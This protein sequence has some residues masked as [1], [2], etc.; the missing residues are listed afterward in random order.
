MSSRKGRKERKSKQ[1]NMAVARRAARLRNGGNCRPLP[2]GPPRLC[3]P[4]R[5]CAGD[6]AV[7]G[8]T[9]HACAAKV[10]RF[11]P[12]AF[13]A[14][15]KGFQAREARQAEEPRT[16]EEKRSDLCRATPPARAGHSGTVSLPAVA[17]RPDAGRDGSSNNPD[18]LSVFRFFLASLARLAA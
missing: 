13:F 14:A 4:P 9:R 1:G 15:N 7:I 5:P 8:R 12:F 17:F 3:A 16:P 18:A 6:G 2:A 10:E 11:F